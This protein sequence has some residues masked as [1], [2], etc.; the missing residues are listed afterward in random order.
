[1]NEDT[2][3]FL[4][5]PVADLSDELRERGLTYK[6]AKKTL[7]LEIGGLPYNRAR[8]ILFWDRRSSN[9]ITKISQSNTKSDTF[10]DRIQAVSRQEP[11]Q[12]F[13]DW[14]HFKMAE[15]DKS[16]S[17]SNEQIFHL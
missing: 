13:L 7:C 3:G 6:R 16:Y 5:F 15:D 17:Y 14:K 4:R 11:Q 10:Q 8:K 2:E 12:I 9:R 1:M